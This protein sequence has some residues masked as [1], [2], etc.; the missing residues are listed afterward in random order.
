[1]STE[2]TPDLLRRA[3]DA[4]V[5]D[6]AGDDVAR[7]QL[8]RRADRLER[9]QRRL[10]SVPGLYPTIVVKQHEEEHTGAMLMDDGCWFT[11]VPVGGSYDH[12]LK[13][14]YVTVRWAEQDD[15][16]PGQTLRE[17]ADAEIQD[18]PTDDPFVKD[19]IERIVAAVIAAY[20]AP[21]LTPVDEAPEP[22]TRGLLP[23]M[24]VAEDDGRGI[25]RSTRTQRFV[26]YPGPDGREV[27]FADP[28]SDGAL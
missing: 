6:T 2:T 18:R 20:A 23:V 7:R 14:H 22:G 25:W 12:Y 24:L 13:L 5:G 11:P 26:G 3:A 1:M 16:T 9:E 17:A 10:P 27:I 8:R 19:Q 4:W 28:R 15:P 21:T